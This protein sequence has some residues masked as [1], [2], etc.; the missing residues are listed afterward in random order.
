LL[1]SPSPNHKETLFAGLLEVIIPKRNG[2]AAYEVFKEIKP[3]VRSLFISGYTADI[4][5]KKGIIESTINFVSK[6][7][8][9]QDLA[10]IVRAVLDSLRIVIVT[11]VV[12]HHKFQP[13]PFSRVVFVF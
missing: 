10:R 5:N 9:P 11:K 2:K 7:I 13:L 3:T 12:L 4:I 1:L 8:A 6:P